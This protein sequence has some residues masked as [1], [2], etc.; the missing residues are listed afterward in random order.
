MEAN[1][2]A[3]PDTILAP[4]GVYNMTLGGAD[5]DLGATGDLDITSNVTIIGLGATRIESQ[6]GRII[7]VLSG[8]V[9]NTGLTL[10]FGDANA[11]NGSGRAGGARHNRSGATLTLNNCAVTDS[12]ATARLI[13]GS[14]AD[15]VFFAAAYSHVD[16]CEDDPARAFALNRDAPAAA[17]AVAARRQAAFVF[18]STEY[19]FDGAAGPY[20]EDDPVRP[21]SVYGRSKLEGE[22]AVLAAHPGALVIRTTV[23]YGYDAQQKNF[24]YQVLKRARAGERITVPADQR[25]SP[26]YLEDLAGVSVVL[27][28]KRLNGVYNVVGP[29]VMDRA[30]FAREVCRVFG[31]DAGLVDGV[32][33]ASLKQKAPRPLAAGLRIDRLRSLGLA[34]RGPA[35]G[36]AAMRQVLSAERH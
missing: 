8:N 36:L 12:T 19:V 18:Y 4:P 20:G 13:E 34:L 26:T 11:D 14:E 16:G 33:T 28:D 23:V 7:H 35:E 17:A 31:L 1:A 25:S 15:A 21:L 10:V 2:L 30:A 6:V 3:G 29:E 27:V 24:V 9:S 22:Q 32:T 5:E